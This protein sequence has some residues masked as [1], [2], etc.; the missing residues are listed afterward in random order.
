[1]YYPI[2]RVWNNLRRRRQ[3]PLN[4]LEA[5]P[6]S[7]K[8]VAK[9]AGVSI[10]TVSRVINSGNTSAASPDTQKRIWDAARQVGYIPNQHARRLRRPEA[11][12][13]ISARQFDCIFA[14]VSGT[15]NVDY[16]FEQLMHEIRAQALTQGYR[17]SRICTLNEFLDNAMPGDC[18]DA[19]VVLG[20]LDCSQIKVLIR[21]YR[22][23]VCVSLQDRELPVD[24]VISRGY[25]AVITSIDYLHSLGHRR[26]CYLGET[27][28]EQRFEAYLHAM[29]QL[30]IADPEALVVDAAFSPASGYDATRELLS[31]KVPFTAILC[32]NDM[33]VLGVLKALNEHRLQVPRDVSIV[34][35]ND[36]EDVRYLD[37]MLTAVNIPIEEMGRH[38]ARLLIDGVQGGHRLPVKMTLPNRLIIRESCAPVQN[39]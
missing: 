14:R 29:G 34:G 33:L 32:A 23:I 15:N 2:F 10:S 22:H 5:F 11:D 25:D 1:M 30:G 17:L 39:K 20:R 9:A 19:A 31:R 27:A 21:H 16:F 35:I 3:I 8:D 24:Q 38:A 13:S 18:A 26:I 7:I 36:K 4:R 6:M 12:S 37:P 28:D